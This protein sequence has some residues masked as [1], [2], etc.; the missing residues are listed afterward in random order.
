MQYDQNVLEKPNVQNLTDEQHQ[1]IEDMGQTMVGWSLPRATG[2]VYAYLL[3]RDDPASLD[4][5]AVDLGVGKSGVSVATRQLVQ[6]G[7]ARVVGERGSRRLRY[8]AMH[9]LEGI[10]AA[11]QTLLVELLT[12][13][14]Q[15][16]AVSPKGP[17]RERLE[18]M[19]GTVQEFIDLAPRLI[20]QLRERSRS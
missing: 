12:R 8:E 4:E 11:R 1:F 3:L 18:E 16:A 2:R 20:A 6:F 15:G 14:R 7:M 19:V 13:L 9:T 10:F 17:R 5:I